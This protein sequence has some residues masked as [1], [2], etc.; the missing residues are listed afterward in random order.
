MY[1]RV[2]IKFRVCTCIHDTRYTI[3]T[4]F[5]YTRL[6]LWC[7][8]LFDGIVGL[9]ASCGHRAKLELTRKCEEEIEAKWSW[10]TKDLHWVRSE[11]AVWIWWGLR[12]WRASRW[13]RLRTVSPVA[14]GPLRMLLCTSKIAEGSWGV[15]GCRSSATFCCRTRCCRRHYRDWQRSSLSYK[16]LL[17]AWQR[18]MKGELYRRGCCWLQM[19]SL[20]S[21]MFRCSVSIRSEIGKSTRVPV[22]FWSHL[23]HTHTCKNC[24]RIWKGSRWAE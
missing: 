15:G 8:I 3:S 13:L 16:I 23:L 1:F 6:H 4:S 7:G 10:T 9:G 14:V 24:T 17:I 2:F 5:V 19:F 11:A 12:I 20:N 21:M 18:S 22:S